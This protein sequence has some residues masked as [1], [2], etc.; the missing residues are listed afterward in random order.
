MDEGPDRRARLTREI[1]EQTGID[2]AMIE[3][4]V[5]TFYARVRQDPLIGPIFDARIDDWDHHLEKLC[6]FWS[7]VALMSGRYHGQP[8]QK[9][10]PLP[11]DGAHFDRWLKLFEATATELCPPPAA[12]HFI[13]RARRIADSLEM[14]IASRQGRMYSPRHSLELRASQR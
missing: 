13:E 10:L 8:M 11:I 12:S 5:H 9:H 3:R 7:A 6:A 1:M 4:L 2:D 14:G